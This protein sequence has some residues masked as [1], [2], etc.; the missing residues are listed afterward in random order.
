MAEPQ[1]KDCSDGLV[2]AMLAGDLDA[3]V[4]QYTDDAVLYGPANVQSVGKEAI[5][6][7]MGEF[8]KVIQADS[9]DWDDNAAVSGDVAYHWGTWT[10][11]GKNKVTGD[12]L[13][14]KAR[15]LDVR[16]RQAD[17]TWLIAADHASWFPQAPDA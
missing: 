13:E 5:R 16:R 8:F 2:R 10:L 7:E 15:T 9:F 4:A 12:D 11:K 1:S 6:A 17:G 14:L 3:F